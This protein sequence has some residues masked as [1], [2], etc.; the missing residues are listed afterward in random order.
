MRV[1]I[2]ECVDPRVKSL[3]TDHYA[4]TVH[5]PGWGALEDGPLLQLARREFDAL[6]TIDSKLEFQH[7]I[8]K[9]QIALIVVHVPKNQFAYYQALQA[10]LLATLDQAVSGMTYHVRL[11]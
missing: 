6:L 3:L 7:N 5:E 2:D 10:E 11:S 9:L 8:A 4:V 1:L